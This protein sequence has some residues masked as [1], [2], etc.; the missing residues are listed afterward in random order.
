MVIWIIPIEVFDYKTNPEVNIKAD[1]NESGGSGGL[2]L[3]LTVYDLLSNDDI[4]KGRVISGTGTIDEN[5]NVGE[6]GG[7]KYKIKGAVKNKA[8]I[9]LV[10]NDNF[11]EAKKIV[12]KYKYKIK[13]V[14]VKTLK[15]AVEYLKK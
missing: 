1:K 3:S 7:V 9:F 13:L 15:E 8:D 10:P 12:K 5:G 4:A 11:K 6:I 14:K 2:M